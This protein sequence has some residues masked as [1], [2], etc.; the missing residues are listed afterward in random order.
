MARRAVMP[1]V[2]TGRVAGHADAGRCQFRRRARVH[3]TDRH[4]RRFAHTEDEPDGEECAKHAGGEVPR[5][6]AK[7]TDE[8][9]APIY[10]E[11]P[12]GWQN[13]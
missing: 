11:F 6:W 7:V 2:L 10:F 4:H 3:W 8:R 1:V 5:H 13:G 9:S 12:E